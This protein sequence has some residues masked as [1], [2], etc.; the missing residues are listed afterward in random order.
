M[1]SWPG[2]PLGQPSE[3]PAGVPKPMPT[4]QGTGP[5]LLPNDAA[6]PIGVLVCDWLAEPRVGS[7]HSVRLLRTS[8]PKPAA[9]PSCPASAAVLRKTASGPSCA[10]TAA[11]PR[12]TSRGAA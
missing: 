10:A 9:K 12:A 7:D 6:T 1:T 3:P 5:D 11:W 2:Q 8:P 4:P